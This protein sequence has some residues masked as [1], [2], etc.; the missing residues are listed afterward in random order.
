[1]KVKAMTIKVANDPLTVRLLD[2]YDTNHIYT[3]TDD[4][5]GDSDKMVYDIIVGSWVI[6]DF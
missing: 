4:E 5:T 2:R 1:M 6:L 3:V